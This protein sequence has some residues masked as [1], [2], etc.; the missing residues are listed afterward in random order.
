MESVAR[1]ERESLP[2]CKPAK[3]ISAWNQTAGIWMKYHEE[4][5][6]WIISILLLNVSFKTK[7]WREWCCFTLKLVVSKIKTDQ[8]YT[9]FN[10]HANITTEN[11]LDLRRSYNPATKNNRLNTNTV[12]FQITVSDIASIDMQSKCSRCSLRSRKLFEHT[13]KIVFT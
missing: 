5:F 11:Y 12:R 2:P 3:W 1:A 10:N 9:E 6:K 7:R 4:D 13:S 8:K